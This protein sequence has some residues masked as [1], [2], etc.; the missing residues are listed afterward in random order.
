[1]LSVFQ[2]YFVQYSCVFLG[3]PKLCCFRE[4]T[5]WITD[6]V[7][8]LSQVNSANAENLCFSREAAQHK[9]AIPSR[10]NG[11]A[12]P[13]ASL[14]VWLLCAVGQTRGGKP[15]P[16]IILPRWSWHSLVHGHYATLIPSDAAWSS[17]CRS[18]KGFWFLS[19]AKMILHSLCIAAPIATFI[20]FERHFRA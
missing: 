12:A 6:I 11:I 2:A 15:P 5:I 14:T 9:E 13:S 1:M 8:Q 3:I 18:S 7:D 10:I 16:A 4:Q 17:G 20:G 19:T